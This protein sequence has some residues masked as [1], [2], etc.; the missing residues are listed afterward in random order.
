M[1]GGAVSVSESVAVRLQS[2]TFFNNSAGTG[3]AM[4]AEYESVVDADEVH[5]SNNTASWSGG[6]LACAYDNIVRIQGGVARANVAEGFGE[7]FV[8]GGAFHFDSG[9]S[10]EVLDFIAERISHWPGELFSLRTRV[11]W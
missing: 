2:V 1:N 3:G 9:N 11:Q 5:F 6:G 10:V 8:G 4:Y 7:G